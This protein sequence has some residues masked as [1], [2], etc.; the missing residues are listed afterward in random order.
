MLLNNKVPVEI[1]NF[2]EQV[3]EI[4]EVRA[5]VGEENG[6]KFYVHSNEQN[7]S[8]PHIHARFNQ[9]EASIS[10]LS[11][12]ILAGNIPGKNLKFAQKWVLCHQEKLLNDWRNMVIS[13]PS[14]FTKSNLDNAF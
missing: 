12:D 13:A 8:L 6:I 7:H 11:G 10:I 2:L 1:A 5:R 4:Y 3:F 14:F 9:Y